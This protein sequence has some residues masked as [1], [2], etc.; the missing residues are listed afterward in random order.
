MKLILCGLSGFC[1]A[2]LFFLQEKETERR[3]ILHKYKIVQKNNKNC[4]VFRMKRGLMLILL[5]AIICLQL[6]LFSV[7]ISVLAK[8]YRPELSGD[9]EIG[10]RIYSDPLNEDD[11]EDILDRYWYKRFWLKYKQKLSSSD[12]YYLKVQ[13][14][15]KD[16]QEETIYNNTSIDLWGNYT[17]QLTKRLKNRWLLNLRHKDYSNNSDNTYRMA[18]LGYQLDYKYNQRHDYTVYLQRQWENYLND[19][20]KDNLY[21]RISL[22]WDFEVTENFELN[23]SL[24]LDREVFN[25]SSASSNKTG[26]KFGVGFKWQL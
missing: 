15:K 21:D 19:S 2:G 18:R 4:G 5:T 23:T 10:D 1:R 6:I 9:F 7:H 16:Y 12:Y 8:D 20:S 25:E 13:Y 14:Y 26:K 22:G 17:Y 3:N 24:Q 11:G